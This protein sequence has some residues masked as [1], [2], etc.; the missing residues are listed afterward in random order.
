[1]LSD[2]HRL[3]ERA[4]NLL[5]PHTDRPDY[6]TIKLCPLSRLPSAVWCFSACYL[7]VP[8][9]QDSSTGTFYSVTESPE[10]KNP[11]DQ[12]RSTNETNNQLS[13]NCISALREYTLYVFN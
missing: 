4:N 1:M 9:I 7:K 11:R 8:L 13:Q 5:G 10:S 2:G 3:N 6:F 12:G